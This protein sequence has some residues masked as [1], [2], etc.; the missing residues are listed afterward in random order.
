MTPLNRMTPVS[1]SSEM[2]QPYFELFCTSFSTIIEISISNHGIESLNR[3]VSK[4]VVCTAHFTSIYNMYCE[5]Q[6][7]MD[8]LERISKGT[9]KHKKAFDLMSWEDSLWWR[10]QRGEITG[11][12][13]PIFVW[14]GVWIANLTELSKHA[15]ITTGSS[16]L[17]KCIASKITGLPAIW[18]KNAASAR[19]SYTGWCAYVS[20]KKKIGNGK[21]LMR[22]MWWTDAGRN[23][24]ASDFADLASTFF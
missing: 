6:L 9:S 23:Y 5:S 4:Y 20:D 7:I 24:R 13:S 8:F 22:S 2:S 16:G 18:N 15:G 10:Q 14:R 21:K 12:S 17:W 19:W 1:V 3:N 11:R